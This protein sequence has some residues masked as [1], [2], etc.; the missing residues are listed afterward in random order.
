MTKRRAKTAKAKP[1][2]GKELQRM[3]VEPLL[4]VERTLIA[5]SLGLGGILL[6]VLIW[7]TNTLFP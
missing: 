3:P 5:W 6:I 4:P 1:D 7:L 2:V